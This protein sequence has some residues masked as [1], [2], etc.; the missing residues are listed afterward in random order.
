MKLNYPSNSE[1]VR[2]VADLKA[3][4]ELLKT[5]GAFRVIRF[6]P[7]YL[8]GYEYWIIN[9]KGF[10]WEPGS[11]LEESE[12]YLESDEALAYQIEG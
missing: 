1:V 8:H 9:E 11:S 6:A 4:F 2:N 12:R 5:V 3:P 7:P 10:L